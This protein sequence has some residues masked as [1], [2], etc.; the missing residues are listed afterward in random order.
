MGIDLSRFEAFHV[1]FYGLLLEVV[2]RELRGLLQLLVD[3]LQDGR[4]V[5]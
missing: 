2:G 1:A 4:V 3:Q 5:A